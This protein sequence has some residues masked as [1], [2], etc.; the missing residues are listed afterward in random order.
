MKVDEEGTD[1]EEMELISCAADAVCEE[2]DI[3]LQPGS[4]LHWVLEAYAR[5]THV[6]NWFFSR[7][8]P[9]QKHRL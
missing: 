6:H 7:S 8:I 3:A 5:A 4:F 1:I 2:Q 9:G